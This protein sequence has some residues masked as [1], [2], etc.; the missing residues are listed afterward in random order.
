VSSFLHLLLLL[1]QRFLTE[2]LLQALFIVGD[3][4]WVAPLYSST[5]LRRIGLPKTLFRSFIKTLM[6]IS[7]RSFNKYSFYLVFSWR[8]G[9]FVRQALL[10]TGKTSAIFL[11]VV[12]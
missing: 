3:G 12:D 2:L 1:D 11:L 10:S 4:H 6:I 9:S 7:A 5:L 8:W